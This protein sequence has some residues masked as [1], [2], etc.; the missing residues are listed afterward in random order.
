M[1]ERYFDRAYPYPK[2]DL[3]AVPDFGAGAMENAGAITFRETR[4]AAFRWLE[5]NADAVF[6]RLSVNGRAGTPWIGARFCRRD[7]QERVR[8]FFAPRL[9]AVNGA[10][11]QLRGAL[12]AIAVCA[13][14][15][16][17]QAAGLARA[18]SGAAR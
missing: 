9:A 6:A 10:E 11:A 1:M 3:I 8:A 15:R 4:D 17:A 18:F 16:E 2:L 13:E 12:E 14:E 5:A 7:D